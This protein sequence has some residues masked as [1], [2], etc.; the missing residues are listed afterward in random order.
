MARN[1]YLVRT[2]QISWTR[3][4][5]P[6][7]RT[8]GLAIDDSTG[9]RFDWAPG[10]FAAYSVFGAGECVFTLAN[11]PCRSGANGQEGG[12]VECTFR[13]VGH[14][15]DALR[16]LGEGETIGI[17]G[18]YGNAFDVEAWKGKHVSFVGGGIGMAA[19]RAPLQYVLDHR[20][21]Y[22]EVTL[23]NGARTA[24]DLVYQSE[25]EAWARDGVDV[26]RTVDTDGESGE[27]DG[28]VGLIPHVFEDLGLS[29]EG[30]V[31]VACGPPIM[32]RFL[33]QA[34]EKTGYGPGQVV[35]TLENKMKCA[36]GHCGRCNV[37]TTYLCTEGPVFTWAQIQEMPND[38]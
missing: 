27:W 15:T 6:D 32:L 12:G 30:R 33:F 9:D 18:P 13:A 34:L 35:T 38:L 5:T 31:V 2:A 19:L 17:R 11:S 16:H 28:R 25:M 29:P 7:V 24:G 10:Q 21:D 14:V 26:V 1:P 4:E 3:E 20:E 8:L 37:G 36:I 22:R 23:L